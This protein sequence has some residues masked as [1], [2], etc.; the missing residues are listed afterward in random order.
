MLSRKNPPTIYDVARSAG[1]SISTVSR[2]LNN[3]ERVNEATRLHVLATIDELGFIP[4]AEAR[5]RALRSAG[6]V[7][8][9]TPFFTAPS[10][11]Q[12]LRGVAS[13]LTESN[14]ELVI[15]TVDTLER[16]QHYL[17]TIP[18]TH[19][20]DGLILISVRVDEKTAERIIQHKLETVLIEYPLNVFSSVE[21][22]DEE[23]GKIAARYLLAKGYPNFA[24]VG[25]TNFPKYGIN[26]ISSRLK[27]FQWVLSE[28][29][30]E[31]TEDHIWETPYHVDA[32][33]FVA[34]ERLKTAKTPLAIF[35]ATDLQAIGVI[36]AVKQM[37]LRIPDDV[38][39]LGFDDLD[40][41][42]YME[43]ST[44]RQPLDE[45]GRVAAELL[46]SRMLDTTRPIQHIRLPLSLIERGTT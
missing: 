12:R 33:R 16:L 35:S 18:L 22:D 4:K 9:I 7:G 32:T 36:K 42:D 41:A 20:L 45:S 30:V 28:S 13:V 21:I 40:I 6:R 29:N 19:N 37:G 17:D 8:V 44:V 46:F 23:G 11:V 39:V 25:E 3:P 31:F 5:A 26:P 38:A 43:L 14:Y 10:F 15:F 1:V 34:L 27:G 24:F 2:V